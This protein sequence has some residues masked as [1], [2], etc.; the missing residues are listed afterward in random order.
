M[1]MVWLW[2]SSVTSVGVS[3]LFPRQSFVVNVGQKGS[4]LFCY[5]F[6]HMDVHNNIACLCQVL[7]HVYTCKTFDAL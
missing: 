6:C 3:S 2:P 1:H 7:I 5:R 4:S